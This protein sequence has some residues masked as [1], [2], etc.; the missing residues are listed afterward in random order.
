MAFPTTGILDSFT[1][2][3][4]STLG[5]NWTTPLIPGLTSPHIISNAETNDQGGGY[6]DAYWNVSTFGSD[7]EVFCVVPVVPSI[8]NEFWLALRAVDPGLS[9]WDGYL[10]DV[11]AP[12]FAW[13]MRR[14]DNNVSTQLGA[15]FTSALANNDA[16]GLEAI[17]ST[18]TTYYKASGGSWA[19]LFSRTDATYSA[20][21]NIAMG[22][23]TSNAT[24]LDDFGG[25]TVVA[26]AGQGP[27]GIAPLRT[28]LGVGI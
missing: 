17:G 18:L 21:G 3:D 10:L 16:A 8:G 4:S 5:A 6:S 1:R 11:L 26:G 12:D 22:Q 20:A 23:G 13:K 2:A 27:L 9:T 24:R 15:T 28:I 25:G 7:S 14:Y 19:A